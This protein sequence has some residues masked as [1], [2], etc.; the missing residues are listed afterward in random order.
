MI[1]LHRKDVS[2]D[3]TV[4][5]IFWRVQW[6]SMAISVSEA[7]EYAFDP[8]VLSEKNNTLWTTRKWTE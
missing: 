2:N 6:G 3:D 5:M 7:A 8:N 1:Y 4:V